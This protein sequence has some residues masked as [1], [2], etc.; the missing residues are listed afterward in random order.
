MTRLESQIVEP[1]LEWC[2]VHE[3]VDE[4][5]SAAGDALKHHP[6]GIDIAP[7]LPLVKTDQALLMQALANILHN[8]GVYTPAGSAIEVGARHSDKRLHFVVS[9]HGPGLSGGE[10]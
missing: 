8:A 2:D 3:L 7:D 10:E 4:A 9:D 1:Q 5:L 6:V